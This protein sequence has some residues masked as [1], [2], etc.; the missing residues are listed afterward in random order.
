[1]PIRKIL[2]ILTLS[3]LITMSFPAFGQLTDV[4]H[5]K[6]GD[7]VT[8]SVSEMTL[9]E[10][11]VET[12]A[13]GFVNIKW[14]DV[15]GFE[16][17]KT[18]QFELASGQRFFGTVASGADGETVVHTASGDERLAN[19]TIVYFS[20]I[21]ADRSLWEGLDKD[22]RVGFSYTQASD[23]LRWNVG[24]G[25]RY[26]GLSYR[27][28][29][30]FA[31][32]TTDNRDGFDTRRADLSGEYQRLLDNRYFWYGSASMQTN[33]ELGIDLRYLLGVGGGRYVLQRR[34]TELVI[35]AGLAGN[36]EKS[37]GDSVNTST[38]DLT[39]EGAL[40]AEWTYYKLHTPSSRIQARLDYFPGITQSGR[41]RANFNVNLKQEFYK[42]MFWVLEFWSSYDS[43]PPPGAF[44]GEDYGVN[45]SLEYNW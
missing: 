3:L 25:L 15:S 45:T 18:I 39:L 4:I 14:A 23:I 22:M 43:D 29:M 2:P 6:N 8:G 17:T 26:K 11:R 41:H 44:S 21:K 1:M 28:S 33:D 37:T 40:G 10:M 20:R 42:D 34:S 35:E 19:E 36:L 7:R 31:S 5:L 9:G 13:M 24:G 12:L 30:H 38:R 27:T 32:Q 16:T